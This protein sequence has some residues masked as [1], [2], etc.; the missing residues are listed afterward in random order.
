MLSMTIPNTALRA[1]RAGMRMSQDDFARAL[2][3]AGHRAGEPNDANKRLVQRWESGTIAAPR[4]IYVRAL[5]VVT[6][7]PIE[8]LGFASL[9]GTHVSGDHKGGHDLTSP[10]SD[11]ATPEP[12]ARLGSPHGSYVGVWLSR[13]QYY[14]SGRGESYA[15]QHYVVLLQHSDRLT[16]RSLPNSAASALSLDLTVDGSV[17]TGTWTEQTAQEGY[18]RGACY[19]GAI[20]MLVEPT[21]RRMAGKWVGFGKDMDINTGPWELVFQDSSTKKS[22]LDRYNTPPRDLSE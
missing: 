12:M 17:I 4:P 14:S 21:G 15:G 16:V 1:V 2:Q 13:Y 3:A 18:Y 10:I 9:P 11:L 20:Q 6:G 5:E 7:L 19:H 22:I 8:L